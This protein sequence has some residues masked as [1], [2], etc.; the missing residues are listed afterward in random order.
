M[1]ILVVEDEYKLADVIAA[2]LKKEKY[3]VD[4][5]TDGE[6]GLYNAESG[7]Y[8][9]IILDVMLPGVNGFEI[10][11][12]IR[13]E[14]IT[15]KVIMLTAK[16]MLEDKLE[17]LT[18]G[19]NDYVT[20]PFHMDELLARVNIQLRQ[21]S[22]NVQKDYI[23]FG[24]IRL[25]TE[26]SSLT[27]TSTGESINVINKEFQLLEYFINNPDRILSKEQIYDKVWGYDNEIES[28][29]LEAYLS[30]IR[31]KLKAIGA[32]VNIK[33]VRGMGYRM[34]IKE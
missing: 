1:R 28:N 24:D 10:L 34:E 23:E 17:G 18:G 8:D 11:S 31:K 4:I 26:T 13:E 25:G 9:L 19:A 29:N 30:F 2:R 21:D 15:S 20:K 16:S 7:I 33:A 32:G 12:Q 14:G 6:D 3:E 27:C 5:S 22:S